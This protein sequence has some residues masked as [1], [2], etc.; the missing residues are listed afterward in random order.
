MGIAD[1]RAM[2]PDVEVV[3]ADPEADRRFLDGIADWCDRYTPLV[4]PCGDDGLFLDV[5][6]CSHLFG[7]EQAMLA[8][9]PARLRMQG[10]EARAGLAATPGMAWAAARFGMREPVA[11]GREASILAALPLTALRLEAQT[12][13]G[14]EGV[15]LRTVGAIIE[16]PRAPLARRF[17]TG[18][19]D[20][21]DEALGRTDEP[22][23]PRLAISPLSAERH[24]AEPVTLI[25]DIENLVLSLAATLKSEMERRCLGARFLR[26]SLFRVDGATSRFEV[27]TSQPVRD[28]VAIR[29][30]FRER[31]TAFGDVDVGYG[32]ELVRLSVAEAMPFP[33]EQSDLVAVD[34][35][36]TQDLAMFADRVRARFGQD[37]LKRPVMA[38]SH[39]PERAASLSSFRGQSAVSA[40]HATGRERFV[41]QER[42]L[43]MLPRPEPVDVMIAEVPEGP[44]LRFR[45]RRTL[46]H[47]TRAEGPERIAPEWWRGDGDAATRDYFRIED[48]GGRRYWLYRLG[49]YGDAP[50]PPRWFLHGIFA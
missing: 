4:A 36:E 47:V 11:A 27:G 20:R 44:P 40:H 48:D 18:L 1:A 13:S 10:V 31:L 24:L 15:G 35:G 28:P 19:I 37:A 2:H 45:W 42:P 14:L 5:T 50:A 8:D 34:G 30:L 21:L 23:S 26:L 25:E 33:A 17:G 39:V 12:R 3:E 46:H 6:G 29:R 7:G 49:L 41:H 32:F 9:I 22:V 43:R 38:E 16:A